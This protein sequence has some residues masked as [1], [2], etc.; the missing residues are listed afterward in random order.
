[1]HDA[2]AHNQVRIYDAGVIRN[3]LECDGPGRR[4]ADGH[5]EAALPGGNGDGEGGRG[6]INYGIRLASLDLLGHKKNS[7]TTS[8]VDGGSAKSRERQPM[9]TS[10]PACY[11]THYLGAAQEGGRQCGP[12]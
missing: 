10:S 4:P 6:R 9:M 3:P 2:L 8:K 1:M 7:A 5:G 11:G 12:P